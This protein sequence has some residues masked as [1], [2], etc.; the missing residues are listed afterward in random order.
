MFASILTT[1]SLI[2]NT[3]YDINK[4]LKKNF[5]Y[6]KAISVLLQYLC[7]FLICPRQTLKN[8]Y[9]FLQNVFYKMREEY[10]ILRG[11]TGN[12][13]WQQGSFV[14]NFI[15]YFIIR[16]IKTTEL[17]KK[18]FS[19]WNIFNPLPFQWV[20]SHIT[21]NLLKT[22]CVLDISR[23]LSL[24]NIK[25]ISSLLRIL[26]SSLINRFFSW[27]QTISAHDLLFDSWNSWFMVL[28]PCALPP[29]PVFG[30]SL[31]KVQLSSSLTWRI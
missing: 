24:K 19:R 29:I 3:N 12:M 17:K 4:V 30:Y 2:G 22:S 28:P 20:E 23:Y 21:G 10:G 11:I 7:D 5:F 13:A 18:T 16:S 27:K 26:Q 8:M 25:Q 14:F 9:T 1:K 31:S 6:I 15:F